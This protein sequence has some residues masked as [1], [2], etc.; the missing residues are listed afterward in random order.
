M[1]ALALGSSRVQICFDGL[2]IVCVRMRDGGGGGGGGG[3]IV[4]Q[5]LVDS[6]VTSAFLVFRRPF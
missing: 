6:L 2:G 3:D 1:F 4:G 5:P